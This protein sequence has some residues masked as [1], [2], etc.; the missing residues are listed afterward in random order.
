MEEYEARMIH[1]DDNMTPIVPPLT[2]QQRLCVLITHDESTFYC[3][4]GKKLFW[5]ENKKKKLLPKSKGSS[6]MVSGFMCPCHGFMTSTI[7]GKIVSS[8]QLFL[9]GT[10]REGWFTNED[11]VHQIDQYAPLF[12]MLHRDCDI[13]LAFDNSMT[14]RA[15]A[16]NGLDALSNKLNLKDG[17]KGKENMCKTRDG[18]Y[19]TANGDKVIQ[20]MHHANGVQKGIKQIL[21]E[22]LLFTDNHNNALKLQCQDCRDKIPHDMR[23]NTT[24]RCC[25]RYVLS[26]QPDFL[27]QKSWLEETCTN[28]GFSTI[29]YP[30]YHCE[31]N[32]IEIIWGFMK[33]YHRRTCT[34]NFKALESEL[35]T[36][37]NERIPLL[38]VQKCFRHCFR[39]MS[40]YRNGLSGGLLDYAVKK[41]TSHR[42]IPSH[43]IAELRV[44]YESKQ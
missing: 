33:A 24:S 13:L 32:F 31:L 40:G 38:F 27:E 20:N 23:K 41:Y 2:S 34:Y 39:F 10:H 7:D 42:I 30:K 25:A 1:Y 18:W 16:P 44:E 17:G 12:K 11:L 8:Y 4:E 26:Q 15:K 37:L 5:M 19:T 28:Y 21:S 22:R 9:A 3:N 29:F 36:T 6:I 43:V 35:P 14:H